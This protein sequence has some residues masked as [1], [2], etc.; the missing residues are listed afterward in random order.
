MSLKKNLDLIV[1][2]TWW[3]SFQSRHPECIYYPPVDEILHNCVTSPSISLTPKSSTGTP[4]LSS[5]K[6]TTPE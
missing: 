1:S 6:A 4:K 3:K 2:S 5:L